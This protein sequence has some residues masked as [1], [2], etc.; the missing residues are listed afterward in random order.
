MSSN[1]LTV[2]L[3]IAE[4]L[5]TG[6]TSTNQYYL[7][8]Y[9]RMLI[10][11]GFHDSD[12]VTKLQSKYVDSTSWNTF[13]TWCGTNTIINTY[14]YSPTNQITPESLDESVSADGP[15]VKVNKVDSL[16]ELEMLMPDAI[17]YWR[18]AKGYLVVTVTASDGTPSTTPTTD[19][20]DRGGVIVFDTWGDM[21]AVSPDNSVV[22]L[23]LDAT[24]DS[25]NV[26]ENGSASYIWNA[27][28][29]D[30][31]VDER[32]WHLTAEH[33]TINVATAWTSLQILS[34]KTLTVDCH[35][36]VM[37]LL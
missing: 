11:L 25:E 7:T 10:G 8:A 19:Q 14:I 1:P 3:T 22:A 27:D 36:A 2:P 13:V 32:Q 17:Y 16:P 6:Y 30:D 29:D 15:K 31:G 26:I 37:R 24:A 4:I 5:A 33:D 20:V 35:I 28:D 18:D 23:V 34:L 12:I 21:T 9:A